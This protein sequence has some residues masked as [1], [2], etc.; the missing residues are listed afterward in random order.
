[1]VKVKIE[2]SGGLEILFGNTRAHDLEIHEINEK[3]TVGDVIVKA[4]D[5]LLT[6]RPELFMKDNSVRPG[7]LVLIN[8]TDWELTGTL[9]T[10]VEDGDTV[11][12]ISTL[13]GG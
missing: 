6:D 2:L 8:D 9:Q 3:V 4:R 13:H 1:M 7:I 5:N 11:T 10:L 12:F